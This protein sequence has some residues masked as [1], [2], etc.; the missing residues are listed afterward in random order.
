MRSM[1]DTAQQQ[2]GH[3]A[4]L[5]S[6]NLDFTPVFAKS[7]S[8]DWQKSPAESRTGARSH[9]SVTRTPYRPT[10]LRLPSVGMERPTESQNGATNRLLRNVL[11]RFRYFVPA[12]TCQSGYGAVCK[13]AYPGSIPGVASKSLKSQAFDRSHI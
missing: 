4:R 1:I 10:P 8:H 2:K 11:G 3:A 12:A 9:H 7:A 5:I 13:T 6:G